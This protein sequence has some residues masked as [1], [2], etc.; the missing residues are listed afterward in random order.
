MKIPMFPKIA[1][2]SNPKI[3]EAA[4]LRDGKYRRRSG[5]FLIDGVREIDRALRAGIRPL[6]VFVLEDRFDILRPVV[7]RS[8][9]AGCPPRFVSDAVFDKIAF[10]RR[11][12]GI[13]VVAETPRHSTQTFETVLRRVETPLLA[14]LERIEKPGNVG[15]IFRGADG[16]GLDGVMI[17]D[18]VSDLFNPNTI[19]SSLGT[20]FRLPSLE[21]DSRTAIAWLRAR[22]IDIAVARCDGAVPYTS[23]DFRRPT[24]VV[25][26]SESEGLSDVWQG[27]GLTAVSLPMDGIADSLNVSNAAAVLFYEARRRRRV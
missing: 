15:A 22:N 3:C 16:A 10:G 13:V 17:C 26:G 25:L 20:V 23:Y 21:T 5:R 1:S 9:L 24:A 8:L 2:L 14:V 27:P 12:E 19:R 18:S 6:D 7:E 11:N 4:K